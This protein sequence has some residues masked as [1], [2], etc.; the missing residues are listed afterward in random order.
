MNSTNKSAIAE[1]FVQ[2][3][4]YGYHGYNSVFVS[5]FVH[6]KLYVIIFVEQSA[7]RTSVKQNLI[8]LRETGQARPIPSRGELMDSLIQMFNERARDTFFP[9]HNIEGMSYDELQKTSVTGS[10]LAPIIAHL[11]ARG[12]P[13]GK[14]AG[15][16]MRPPLSLSHLQ[17][18]ELACYCNHARIS[19]R[20]A[21]L[22]LY[23]IKGRLRL[24]H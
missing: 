20:D 11:T 13:M 15:S 7:R 5:V 19:G 23:N 18:H 10:V 16:L 12:I 14:T 9:I 22:C 8:A 2:G 3:E 6:G 4:I 1:L 24:P 21:A 17:I